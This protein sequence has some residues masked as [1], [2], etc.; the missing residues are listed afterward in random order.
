MPVPEAPAI[1]G[2]AYEVEEWLRKCEE[3]LHR[4]DQPYGGDGV[5]ECLR[6]FW[7]ANPETEPEQRRLDRE[8]RI[9]TNEER[10]L[11]RRRETIRMKD[12]A[13]IFEEDE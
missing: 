12:P 5:G 8:R 7:E 3:Y 1:G 11:Q 9:A 2:D 6:A 10:K 4:N 13:Y